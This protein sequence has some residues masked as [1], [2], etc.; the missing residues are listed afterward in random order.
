MP[1]DWHD[2]WFGYCEM[3]RDKKKWL[4]AN[5]VKLVLKKLR[6]FTIAEQIAALNKSTIAG[7]TDVYPE[8]ADGAGGKLQGELY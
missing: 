5:A 4:T 8:R 2:A 6:G 1:L 3:R 7:Y